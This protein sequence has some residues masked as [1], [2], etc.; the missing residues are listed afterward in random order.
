LTEQIDGIEYIR[1]DWKAYKWNA[2]D[3]P[4]K[5]LTILDDGF[6]LKHSGSEGK[7]LFCGN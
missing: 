7:K 5:K 2:F 6:I 4:P 3:Y 1:Y